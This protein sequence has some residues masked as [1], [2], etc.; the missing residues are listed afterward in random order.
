[1]HNAADKANAAVSRSNEFLTVKR[2]RFPVAVHNCK[3]G[4][5]VKS[6]DCDLAWRMKNGGK[7]RYFCLTYNASSTAFAISAVPFLP[8]NSIG[9]IPPA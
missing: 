8:P 4:L 3:P 1:M 6:S 9:L 2:A 7:L 5:D